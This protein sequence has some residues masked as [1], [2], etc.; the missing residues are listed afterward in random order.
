MAPGD[1]SFHTV[2]YQP[3]NQVNGYRTFPSRETGM[4]HFNELVDQPKLLISGETGDVIA[5]SG[6]T[7]EVDECLGNFFTARYNGKYFG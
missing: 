3:N 4:A 5:S 7:E 2:N 6:T 1:K